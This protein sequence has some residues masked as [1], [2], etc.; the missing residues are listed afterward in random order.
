M[1]GNA[2]SCAEYF[3][4]MHGLL[5]GTGG[6]SCFTMPRLWRPWLKNGVWESHPESCH[7][8]SHVKWA[9]TLSVKQLHL[10][11][12]KS[13]LEKRFPNAKVPNHRATWSWYQAAD[14]KKTQTNWGFFPFKFFL[15]NI[16]FWKKRLDFFPIPCPNPS[17]QISNSKHHSSVFVRSHYYYLPPVGWLFCC[18]YP[19]HLQDR[20]YCQT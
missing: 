5:R 14:R 10:H 20:K 11:F 9:G 18:V 7:L 2:G 16:L 17:W 15:K 8:L 4:Q 12:N 19:P 3:S 1:Q 13:I 6:Y